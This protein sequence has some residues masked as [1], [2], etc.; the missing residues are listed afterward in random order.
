MARHPRTRG[1]GARFTN[2]S[3]KGK[4]KKQNG[5]LI[6]IESPLTTYGFA[7]LFDHQKSQKTKL[8][9]RRDSSFGLK[10]MPVS[11]IR[12]DDRYLAQRNIPKSKT[13]AGE[14]NRTCGLRHDR[15]IPL[16]HAGQGRGRIKRWRETHA[17]GF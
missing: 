15:R 13:L 12:I 9:D 10:V 4:A 1:V 6:I 14:T 3:R 16:G 5:V 2:E 8:A 7:V 11:V 17:G